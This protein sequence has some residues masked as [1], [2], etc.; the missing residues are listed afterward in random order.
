MSHALT[1][2]TMSRNMASLEGVFQHI[3]HAQRNVAD[4]LSVLER[5]ILLAQRFAEDLTFLRR[6]I[7]GEWDGIHAQICFLR[8]HRAQVLE[9]GGEDM[10]GEWVTDDEW[11][12][13]GG[14]P[15]Q[16]EV[17][18]NQSNKGGCA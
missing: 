15:T 5:R 8:R 11:E 6:W 12:Q 18:K 13:V 7:A 10:D 14:Q 17:G 2:L 3:L 9:E 16:E 1:F 4:R